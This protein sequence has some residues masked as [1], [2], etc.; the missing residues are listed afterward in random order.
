MKRPI[1][2]VIHDIRK[3]FISPNWIDKRHVFKGFNLIF[4]FF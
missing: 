1:K 3:Y 4:F 2:I